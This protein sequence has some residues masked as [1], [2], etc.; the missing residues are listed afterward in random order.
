[1][2]DELLREKICELDALVT[3]IEG[4][5]SALLGVNSEEARDE[6]EQGRIW[7]ADQI[8][9]LV[10]NDLRLLTDEILEIGPGRD[11]LRAVE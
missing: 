3:R 8:Y 1:M 10:S 9:G 6:C 7:L 5:T 11:R 2:S 4:A